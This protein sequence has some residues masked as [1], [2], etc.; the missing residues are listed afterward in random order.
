MRQCEIA[1]FGINL[2]QQAH[3]NSHPRG[4]PPS[5][6]CPGACAGWTPQCAPPRWRNLG[7]SATCRRRSLPPGYRSAPC[8]CRC[9]S[10]AAEGLGGKPVMASCWKPQPWQNFRVT[11]SPSHPPCGCITTP[12]MLVTIVAC[13]MG[14]TM[15]LLGTWEMARCSKPGG[16]YIQMLFEL[17]TNNMVNPTINLPGWYHPF[18]ASCFFFSGNDLLLDW[19]RDIPA[20]TVETENAIN[21][22]SWM[23]SSV[24]SKTQPPTGTLISPNPLFQAP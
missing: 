18:M 9:R 4:W 19:P 11:K 23:S 16:C 5:P 17:Y 1:H 13:G 15:S 10:L 7:A 6:R 12:Q 22:V 8:W 14:L 21:I 2:H 3:P 20:T 24:N